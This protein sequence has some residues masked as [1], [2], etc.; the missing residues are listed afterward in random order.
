MVD[1]LVDQKIKIEDRSNLRNPLLQFEQIVDSPAL[2]RAIYHR[3]DLGRIGSRS[4][5]RS[6]TGSHN[7]ED[8]LSYFSDSVLVSEEGAC[9]RLRLISSS[10]SRI[11]FSV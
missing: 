5:S 3:G 4:H 8:A 6:H 7:T 1:D 9:D 10:R 2:Q 11:R